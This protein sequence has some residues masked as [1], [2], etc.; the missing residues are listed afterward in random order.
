MEKKLILASKSP[1]RK[2]LLSL[3]NIP[4]ETSNVE[5][6]ESF[7]DN[8]S[9]EDAIVDIAYKKAYAVFKDNR[10]SVVLGSDTIVAINDTILGK[11]K[12]EEDARRMLK[13]LSNKKHKVITGTVFL[14]DDKVIKNCNVSY[15][16]FNE[17]SDKEIDDYIKSKEPLDKAGAYAIQGLGGCFINKIEGDY[18]SIMGLT[19]NFVYKTLHSLQLK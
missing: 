5:I 14:Y 9:L 19:L 12:D 4:F 2:E 7:D 16:Y 10:D 13:L 6:D 15:V 18:Y 8:L 11:P 1:R 17:L 3:C